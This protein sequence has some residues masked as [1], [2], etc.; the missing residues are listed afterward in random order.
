VKIAC[1]QFI[2]SIQN[3]IY[4]LNIPHAHSFVDNRVTF[5]FGLASAHPNLKS[6]V[7]E[8]IDRADQALYQTKQGGRNNYSIQTLKTEI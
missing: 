5:S 8:L 4:T 7:Q 6:S 1:V 2:K 3:K